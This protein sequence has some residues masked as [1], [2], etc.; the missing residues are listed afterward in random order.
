MRGFLIGI[1]FIVAAGLVGYFLFGSSNNQ[2]FGG[3]GNPLVVIPTVQPIEKSQSLTPDEVV[4]AA[5]TGG[6]NIV[7]NTVHAGAKNIFLSLK[8]SIDHGIISLGKQLGIVSNSSDVSAAFVDNPPRT[9]AVSG[10]GAGAATADSGG[11][12]VSPAAKVNTTMY[13]VVTT[14]DLSLQGAP[15]S[16]DWGDGSRNTGT[17]NGANQTIFHVWHV[18]GSFSVNF[19]A[20]SSATAAHY[21]FSVL[22]TQ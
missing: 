2:L 11:I 5:L 3:G 20:S 18:F 21:Q 17:I 6:K 15:Y 12:N 22:V 9:I 14:S 10:V 13:F 7:S 16:V 8:D 4:G 19:S 1:S